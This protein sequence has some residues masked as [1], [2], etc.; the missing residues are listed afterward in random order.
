MPG[1]PR[2]EVAAVT[3]YVPG[4]AVEAVTQETGITDV[5]KLASNERSASPAPSVVE[6]MSAAAAGTNRYPD[7]R[8]E[9]LRARLAAQIGTTPETI[10]V[11][12]GSVGL[13]QQ[14]TSAYAGPGRD[15]VFPWRSFE[16]YPILTQLSGAR[17]ITPPLDDGWAF[18]VPALIDAITP[19]TTLMHLATPNNPT[20]TVLSRTELDSILDAVDEDVIV[21]VD[22]AYREYLDADPWDPAEL[23]ANHPNV[24]HLR[25]FSKAYALAAARVGW[26]HA[27][28]EVIATLHATQPPFPVT[29]MGLAGAA[30]ALDAVDELSTHIEQVRGERR[31]VSEQVRS[32][33]YEPPVD[34]QGN[35]VWIPTVEALDV[36]AEL[37]QRGVVVRPFAGEGIRVTI[38]EPWENDRF[39]DALT[40]V[41]AV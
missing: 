22:E 3:G 16:L 8:A 6:A 9:G 25:T 5:V 34:Q 35:F 13:L 4:K 27:H 32:L 10:A 24:I 37:E 14:I 20:G 1:R 11:S 23:V 30:A 33:G 31:R 36:T 18:D 17:A 19:D 29:S 7:N 38:G 28:P 39:I 12:S 41:N 15:V 2:S 40:A 26:C 21:V